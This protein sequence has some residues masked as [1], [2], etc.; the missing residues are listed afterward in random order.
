MADVNDVAA[1]D[2]T[3]ANVMYAC[4]SLFL[5]YLQRDDA[6]M[7]CAA[8]RALSYI[9]IARP[10][11]MLNLEQDGTIEDLMSLDSPV[12]LQ[13]ESLLCWKEILVVSHVPFYM[14]SCFDPLFFRSSHVILVQLQS[15]ANRVDSV[16][17]PKRK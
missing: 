7:K 5:W 10:P 3:S 2:M 11:V 17:K 8:L 12:E 4:Y 13:L 6:A 14:F 9:F 15:E 16:E 1:Q